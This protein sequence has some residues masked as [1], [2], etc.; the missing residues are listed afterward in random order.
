MQDREIYHV[1]ECEVQEM[2]PERVFAASGSLSDDEFEI[3][4][5]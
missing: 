5:W 4:K 1:P 3:I 2:V